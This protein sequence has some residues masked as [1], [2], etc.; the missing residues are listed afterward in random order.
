MKILLS[1]SMVI[2][3][4]VSFIAIR[5]VVLKSKV[6]HHTDEALDTNFPISIADGLSEAIRFATISYDRNSGRELNHTA[7]A[8][9]NEYIFRS[10]SWSPSFLD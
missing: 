10:E 8:G 4:L 2:A 3:G 7:F 5:T 1:I 9:L 6:D